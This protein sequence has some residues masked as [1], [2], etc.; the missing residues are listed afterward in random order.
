MNPMKNASRNLLAGGICATALFSALFSA[1]A[2]V[3]LQL[4]SVNPGEGVVLQVSGSFNIGPE[5]V[6]AGIYNQIIN[7][8]HPTTPSFCIDVARDITIGQ[9]Y[10]DYSYADLSLS[11]LAP[12]GPTG[13]SGAV[14]IEKLWAAYLPAAMGNSQDAAALQVAIWKEVA[15]NVGYTITVNGNDLSDPVY[16]E[17]IN[18]LNSLPNL[19]AQASLVGLTSPTGQNYVVPG[20]S[21]LT[22]PE[23]STLALA[24]LGALGTLLLRRR[25]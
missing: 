20:P 9:L 4:D 13:A 10:T 6:Y 16:A 25:K 22:V 15:V 24:G 17:A 19:T 1:N 8:V 23:P 7:G 2:Q 21:I 5:G 3:T 14:N 11:P 18:M 12:S